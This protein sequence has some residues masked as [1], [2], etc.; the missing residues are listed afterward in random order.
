MDKQ[1]VLVT[2]SH[3][4]VGR[5]VVQEMLANG[6]QVVAVDKNGRIGGSIIVD[7]EDPGQVVSVMHGCNAVIHLAA[8]PAPG[9]VPDAVTF[10][11]NVISTFNILEAANILGIKKVVNASSIS[12]LGLAFR[13]RDF[14][15]EKIPIDES[16]PLLAQDAY[17][18]SKIVGEELAAGFCRRIPDLSVSSLRFAM[19]I[20][21]AMRQQLVAGPHGFAESFA[22]ILWSYIDVRDTATACRLA[23]EN[24]LPGH[25][26]FYIAA[27]RM[28]ADQPVEELLAKYFPGDYPVAAQVRGDVSPFDCDKARRLLGW[29]A[30]YDWAGNLI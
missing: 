5:A 27:P 19:V 17:G 22:V 7:C 14:N 26:A 2:G 21:D 24:H 9:I 25:E 6:Y 29:Q 16:H 15:P 30:V 10:R 18:L 12:A 20:G 8:Y 23:I 3:G 13:F 11:T 28:I 1:K 4:L